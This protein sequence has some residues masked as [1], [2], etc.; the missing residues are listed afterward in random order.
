M[1]EKGYERLIVKEV[2]DT[3]KIDSQGNVWRYAKKGKLSVEQIREVKRL[4][5]T[6]KY[7]Q[8]ELASK[9]GLSSQYLGCVINGKWGIIR[10][11]KVEARDAFGYYRIS[12]VVNGKRLECKAHRLVWQYFF[13]DI[14]KGMQINHKNGKKDDNRPEN[15]EVVTPKENGSHAARIGLYPVG[16]KNG[17]AKLTETQ[18]RE[19]RKIYDESKYTKHKRKDLAKRF[20]ISETHILYI[21]RR[22]SWRHLK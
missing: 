17:R 8:W 20:G 3:L 4:Y 11:R 5:A 22:L 7:F 21:V 12:A 18:V 15:L 2:G 13:G 19:M 1:R 9:Y 10:K 14:P 6:G 16:E